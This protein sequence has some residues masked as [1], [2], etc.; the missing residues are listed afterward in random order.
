MAY[1]HGILGA[2]CVFSDSSPFDSIC[3]RMEKGVF[4]MN[5]VKCGD[6]GPDVELMQ[7]G[8]RRSGYYRGKVDGLF[9]AVSLAALLLFQQN[10]G[11]K[12][13]GAAG[14]ETWR[15]LEPY[16]S[17]YFIYRI[18]SGDT[19]YY[20]ASRYGTSLRAIETANPEVDP[21]RLAVGQ[22][23]VIPFGFAVVATDIHFTYTAMELSIRGLMARYPFLKSKIIGETENGR[24][25]YALFC[26]SG[27]WK[28]LYNA[29]HH[30][31]EWITAPLLLK[32]LENY[33][34]AYAMGG[35][36]SGYPAAQVFERAWMCLIPM[37][38]PDGVDL[39]TGAITADT[40]QYQKAKAIADQFPQI[41]FP[42]GWS[43]NLAG[44]DLNVNYPAGW[45]IA[46]E[47]KFSLGYTKP[48]PNFFPGN[49]PLDQP[50]SRAMA[51]FTKEF[52]PGLTL[53]YHTQGKV[54]YWKYLNYEPERALA[55]AKLFSEVSGYSLELTPEISGYAGYKDWFI[56]EFN[57]PGYTIEAGLG[58]NPLP[59]SAFDEIYAENHGILTLGVLV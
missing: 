58:V 50:E 6:R 25:I 16:L 54:I 51:E 10:Y 8:L 9:G 46:R 5:M 12:A 48:A 1:I 18:R 30:A 27:N 57:R 4:D 40:A 59:P 44:V 56:Q 20:L 31:N 32:Y 14:E 52:D 11:L 37:V 34:N 23:I 29:A 45:D 41:P 17:G 38:N 24:K 2:G 19:F 3:N 28:V 21:L 53:A 43:A 33:A 15:A 7:T 55:I 13:D 47:I 22:P 39:V 35:K 36:I 26:G 42:D 49:A